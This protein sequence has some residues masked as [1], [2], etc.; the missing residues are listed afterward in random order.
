MQIHAILKD[1][2][3]FTTNDGRI[4]NK[5]LSDEAKMVLDWY[6]KNMPAN[7]K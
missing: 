4:I 2:V 7:Q 3:L 6:N 1:K 5:Q